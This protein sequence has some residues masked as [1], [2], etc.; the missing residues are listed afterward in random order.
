VIAALVVALGL[1]ALPPVLPEVMAATGVALDDLWLPMAATSVFAL[2]AWIT[3]GM[4]PALDGLGPRRL[5]LI[6]LCAWASGA[7]VVSAAGS[8]AALS[9]G[10]TLQGLGAGLAVAITLHA[11]E[12][13]RPIARGTDLRGALRTTVGAVCLAGPPLGMA[14]SRAASWRVIQRWEGVAAI[15]LAWLFVRRGRVRGAGRPRPDGLS[16]ALTGIAAGLGLIWILHHGHRVWFHRPL[17]HHVRASAPIVLAFVIALGALVLRD[18]A[19]PPTARPVLGLRQ[20]R[21]PL[22]EASGDWLRVPLG[23]LLIA[24]AI[25]ADP[26]RGGW[27][28][29]LPWLPVVVGALLLA[30]RMTS[31]RLRPGQAPDRGAAL[32]TAVAAL[33]GAALAVVGCYV[34]MFARATHDRH[35]AHVAAVAGLRALAAFAVAAAV[36]GWLARHLEAR[37]VGIAGLLCAVGGLAAASN[38]HANAFPG[39]GSTT[40]LVGAGGG[41]G[42]AALPVAS[43]RP[44]GLPAG[45]SDWLLGIGVGL[46][47]L[48]ARG[49]TVFGDRLRQ[50][51]PASDLC[52]AGPGQ[53]AEYERAVREAALEEFRSVFLGAALC[54]ALAATLLA[55]LAPRRAAVDRQAVEST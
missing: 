2:G 49:L 31:G 5:M 48:T 38:W 41:L 28:S 24:G 55:F 3:I 25:V 46:G 20:I 9:T 15:A 34:P 50:V 40:A 19:L 42:L 36:G 45:L 10:R 33:A 21:P 32:A 4:R 47:A 27:H 13:G 22:G 51:L 39:A 6:G 11:I 17:V 18:L 37:V 23:A 35:S 26:D 43:L 29:V 14:L 16:V 7:F 30:A 8:T 52:P 44:R 53:C 1:F 54:A 12:T